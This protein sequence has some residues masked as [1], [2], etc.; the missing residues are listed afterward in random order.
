M[1]SVYMVR[2]KKFIKRHDYTSLKCIWQGLRCLAI[3]TI[4]VP[5]TSHGSQTVRN[6]GRSTPP[7]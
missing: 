7:L 6:H 2:A 5:V 3:P 4:E 1:G